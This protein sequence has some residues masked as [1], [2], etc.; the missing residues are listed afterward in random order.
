MAMEKLDLAI[1]IDD[2]SWTLKSFID[3]GG[4]KLEQRI[5]SGFK[6]MDIDF[7]VV[8]VKYGMLN[9]TSEN[10]YRSTTDEFSFIVPDIILQQNVENA[11]ALTIAIEETCELDWRTDARKICFVITDNPPFI[12]SPECKS[13]MDILELTRQLGRKGVVLNTIGIEPRL[14]PYKDFF[15]ALSYITGGRYITI[16]D[17]SNLA[18][19]IAGAAKEDISLEKILPLVDQKNC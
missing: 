3:A 6:E 4:N 5:E 8:C 18:A 13:R 7:R 9:K 12:L 1:V 14:K 15:M 16:I 17:P 10:D 11:D 2:S 19:A